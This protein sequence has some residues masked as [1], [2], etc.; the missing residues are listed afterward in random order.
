MF[1]FLTYPLF[2][3]V[4]L[5]TS[6]RVCVWRSV[7]QM[8]R[9]RMTARQNGMRERETAQEAEKNDMVRKWETVSRG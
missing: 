4:S 1:P 8:A 6:H 7:K 9:A 3:T 5:L 2:S